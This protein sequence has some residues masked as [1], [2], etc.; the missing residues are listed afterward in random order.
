MAR[1]YIP[2]MKDWFEQVEPSTFTESEFEM[3]VLA[4]APSVY[5][6][7]HVLP[8]KQTLQ[9]S[10]GNVRPDL[11]FIATDYQEWRIVE[12]EMGYHDLIRHIEPQ[13]EKLADVKYDREVANYIYGKKPDMDIER[14]SQLIVDIPPQVLIIVNEDKPNWVKPL[15]KYG[16]ILAVF[17]LFRS[18]QEVEIFRVDGE[19]PAFCIDNLCECSVHPTV[20]RLLG[21]T[22]PD[23]LNLPPRGRIKLRYN[24]CVTEWE[25]LD[26]ENQVWLNPVGRNPLENNCNYA[27]FR[28]RDNSLVLRLYES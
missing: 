8:F 18:D 14:L 2:E 7:Y 11:V 15:S 16:A 4:H 10:S 24:N 19:Y 1:V 20:P 22:R 5:P 27:I 9:S 6:E 13:V 12:V 28:Q 21:I 25:R 23:A 26:A 3:R 17:E